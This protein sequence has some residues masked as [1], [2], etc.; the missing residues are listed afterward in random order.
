[1]Q[2]KDFLFLTLFFFF[3]PSGAL[4]QAIRNFAKSL[5][6]WLTGAMMDIPEEMVRVKVRLLVSAQC[7]LFF[8][9]LVSLHFF[10]PISLL[11]PEQCF[12]FM[13]SVFLIILSNNKNNIYSTKLILLHFFM[14]FLVSM[15]PLIQFFEFPVLCC[16]IFG[17]NVLFCFI[18]DRLQ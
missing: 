4:T 17:R 2:L 5:E 8:K 1:M 10:M 18:F 7:H 14:L 15:N 12:A 13:P 3:S 11:V 6:S 16:N 9:G